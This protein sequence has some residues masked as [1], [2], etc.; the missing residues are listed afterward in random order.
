MI[1]SPLPAV[2]AV[3][4]LLVVVTRLF[5]ASAKLTL[6]A[7]EYIYRLVYHALMEV[8]LATCSMDKIREVM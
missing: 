4:L 2:I 3:V 1:L 7:F 5:R 8:K 6:Y